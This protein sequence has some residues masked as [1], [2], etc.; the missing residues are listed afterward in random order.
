MSVFSMI[1]LQCREGAG[2]LNVAQVV[3]IQLDYVSG[4]E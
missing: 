1:V 4:P 3:V 2:P